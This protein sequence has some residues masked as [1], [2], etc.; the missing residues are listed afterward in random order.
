M[1]RREFLV[2]A[3]LTAGGLLAYGKMALS[4]SD[5]ATTTHQFPVTHTDAEWRKLLTPAQYDILRDKGTEPPGSGK[6][7]E[8]W[9]HG[10]YVCAA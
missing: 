6:Y 7:N 10:T 1:N 5:A 9:Q 3:V 4:G 2:S 8:F